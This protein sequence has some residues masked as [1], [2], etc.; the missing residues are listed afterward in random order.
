[1]DLFTGRVSS[2]LHLGS[3]DSAFEK[4]IWHEPAMPYASNT[5]RVRWLYKFTKKIKALKASRYGSR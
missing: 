2:Y 4:L 3:E 5:N 1:M